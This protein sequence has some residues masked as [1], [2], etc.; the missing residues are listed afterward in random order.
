MAGLEAVQ[1]ARSLKSLEAAVDR[2]LLLCLDARSTAEL[3]S[4]LAQLADAVRSCHIQRTSMRAA[5]RISRILEKIGQTAMF[6]HFQSLPSSIV[7]ECLAFLDKESLLSAALACKE[8]SRLAYSDVVWKPLYEARFGDLRAPAAIVGVPLMPTFLSLFRLRLISPMPGDKIEVLWNGKFRLENDVVYQGCAW[9]V[10]EVVTFD[11]GN[12]RYLVHY[13]GWE[14]RWNEWVRRDRLRWAK[15]M[16]SDGD[17]RTTIKPKD[18]IEIWCGGNNVP[19]AWLEAKVSSVR[20]GA[21]HVG[22]VVTAGDP[23]VSTSRV[24]RV[25]WPSAN[26]DGDALALCAPFLGT[27]QRAKSAAVG[28]SWRGL[29]RG[30]RSRLRAAQG[31]VA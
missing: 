6:K 17:R 31:I 21:V 3:T 27:H 10:A 16:L 7:L 25:K 12:D 1:R 14:A 22:D 29:W 15:P 13:P 19:G 9:W 20:E 26:N 2:H 4:R 23:W 8:M 30:L 18:R 11:A 24:R 5:L 28:A